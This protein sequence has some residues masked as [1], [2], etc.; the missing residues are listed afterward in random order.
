MQTRRQSVA[1]GM[2]IILDIAKESPNWF[3]PLNSALSSVN[4]FIRHYE[5]WEGG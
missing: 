2:K 1:D 3:P 5:V 4:T